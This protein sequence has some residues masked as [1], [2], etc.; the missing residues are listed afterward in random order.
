VSTGALTTSTKNVLFDDFLGT[1]QDLLLASVSGTWTAFRWNGSTFVSSSTGAPFDPNTITTTGSIPTTSAD[2]DGDGLPDLVWIAGPIYIRRNTSTAS[3]VS[4]A[5]TAT[6]GLSWSGA[7]SPHQIRGNNSYAESSIRQ[8]DFDADGRDDILFSTRAPMEGGP[9]TYTVLSR[10]ASFNSPTSSRSGQTDY[11][12]PLKWN[13]DQCTDLGKVTTSSIGNGIFLSF[14]DGTG[15]ITSGMP[16]PASTSGRSIALDWDG[17]NRTDVLVDSAGTWQLYRSLDTAVATP[18]STGISVGSGNWVAT[19]QNGDGLSD[20]GFA[21]SAASYAVSYGLHHGANAP[22]DLATSITDGFGIFASFAYYSIAASGGCYYRDSAAPVY[23]DRAFMGAIYTACSMTASDGTGGTY[24]TNF[25]YYNANA[26]LQGRGLLGF[27]R[28]YWIDNRDGIVNMESYGQSFPYIGMVAYFLARQSDWVTKIKEISHTFS[29][30]SFGT[31]Y[32]TRAHPFVSQSIDDAFEVG[33]PLNGQW[34]TRMTQTLSV[35]SFGNPT[36][37]TTTTVDQST[38]SPFYGET[39]TEQT[40]NTIT[41]DTVNWCLG[42]PSQTTM[43][44]T[45]PG[46]T[47]Q[48]RTSTATVDYVACRNT[49]EVVEPASSTLRMTTTYG[50]L[51]AG[52]GNPTSVSVVGKNPDGSDMVARTT[53]SSFGSRCLFPESVTN[54]LGETSTAAYDYSLGVQIGRTDPNGLTTSW[55]YDG[56]GRKTL[57]TRPDGTST[58]WSF[59]PCDAS[60]G[61]CGVSDLRWVATEVERDSASA[62]ITYKYL[63]YDGFNRLRYDERLNLAGGLTYVIVGY[64]ARGNQSYQYNPYTSASNGYHAFSYDLIDRP[65]VSAL[66]NGAG[67]WDRQSSIV[68]AGRAVTFTDPKGNA[69]TK[70]ADVRGKLRRVVD[71]SPGGTTNYTYDPFGNLTTTTDATGAGSS[72]TY[73][74]RGFKTSSYDPDAG[75]WTYTPNSLGEIVSQT[76]AKSQTTT[77]TYDALGRMTSRTE[78]EGVSTWTWGTSSAAKNIGKLASLGGAG[79][80]GEL[81]LRLPRTIRV[82]ELQRGRFL[83]DRLHVQ[84]RHGLSRHRLVSDEHERLPLQGAVRL[85]QRHSENRDRCEPVCPVRHFRDGALAEEHRRRTR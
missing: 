44:S 46:G 49:Q 24:Q 39:Y 77:F 74:L 69:R 47:S 70:Y 57:E 22:A 26:N 15:T 63:F 60:N 38:S 71:P 30:L 79:L 53:T 12:V 80:L 34:I 50:Y 2:T 62:Q 29:Q 27:E 64:D 7:G 31:G 73:N 76:D 28:R 19:D 9:S 48:T 43:Q 16:L 59:S 40:V 17:D 5:A 42:R 52:C 68:Y 45:V 18:V 83:P 1:G 37:T 72:T 36:T 13:D 23:P 3:V 10:G 81:R 35:D 20:L 8:L 82:H 4:F 65:T 6:V 58:A 32:D 14:C 56:Y 41:N 67:A 85:P 55:Q 51:P 54:P 84:R 78:V 61:Y 21:N 75:S 11:F 66:Y 33:G 25:S